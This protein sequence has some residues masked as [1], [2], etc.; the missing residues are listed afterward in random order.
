MATKKVREL[1]V[2]LQNVLD[3]YE[4]GMVNGVHYE[5]SIVMDDLARVIRKFKPKKGAKRGRK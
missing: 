3:W 1:V 5:Q 4:T 2:A